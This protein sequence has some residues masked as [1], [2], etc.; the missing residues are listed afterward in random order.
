MA[1]NP[2]PRPFQLGDFSTTVTEPPFSAA[3]QAQAQPAMPAP[4][5]RMS[6]STV[7]AISVMGSGA[8]SHAYCA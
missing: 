7:L 4:M 3:E 5:M 2:P 6:A 1:P 8:T